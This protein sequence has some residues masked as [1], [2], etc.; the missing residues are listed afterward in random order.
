M[1]PLLFL[2]GTDVRRPT[3]DRMRELL[4]WMLE[5]ETT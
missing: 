1:L 3:R 5:V 4:V 2:I